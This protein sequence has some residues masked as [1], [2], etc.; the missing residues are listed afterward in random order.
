MDKA[1]PLSPSLRP[2]SYGRTKH[3]HDIWANN[4]FPGGGVITSALGGKLAER[5]ITRKQKL[6]LVP[7]K[8]FFFLKAQILKFFFLIFFA[9]D[10]H[11][12]IIVPAAKMLFILL[13]SDI[14]QGEVCFSSPISGAPIIKIWFS[15]PH[16][17][18][19]THS[20]VRRVRTK[21]APSGKRAQ[22]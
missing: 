1:E 17:I 15:T 4:L 7:R 11:E 20:L 22:A 10:V 14:N 19:S 8:N 3:D 9:A 12:G 5:V 16:R 18:T 13:P 6:C 2:R 21:K